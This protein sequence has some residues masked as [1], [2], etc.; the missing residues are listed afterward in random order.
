MFAAVLVD[1]S[2]L[3]IKRVDPVPMHDLVRLGFGGLLGI[4]GQF[5]EP[6]AGFWS[7]ISDGWSDE[8]NQI[9]VLKHI[10]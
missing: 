1:L 4:G 10:H 3:F 9:Q 8:L 6:C 7:D 2:I 5:D